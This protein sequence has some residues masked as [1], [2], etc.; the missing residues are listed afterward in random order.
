MI[1]PVGGCIALRKDPED[2]S[3][4]RAQQA[5]LH[6]IGQSL[7][8]CYSKRRGSKPSLQRTQNR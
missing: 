5:L 2:S 1:F 3:R 4:I 6:G 7:G 8:V